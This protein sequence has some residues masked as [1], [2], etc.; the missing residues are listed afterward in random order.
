MFSKLTPK[1]AG[2]SAPEIFRV[3]VATFL[4]HGYGVAKIGSFF[5]FRYR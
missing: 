5:I 1:F 4:M 3:R 2:K